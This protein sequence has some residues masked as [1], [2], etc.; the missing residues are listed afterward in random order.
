MEVDKDASEVVVSDR[1][2]SEWLSAFC[3]KGTRD[4]DIDSSLT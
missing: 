2:S 1:G 4:V 3:P